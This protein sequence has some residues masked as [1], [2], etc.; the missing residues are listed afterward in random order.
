MLNEHIGVVFGVLFFD[1]L[2]SDMAPCVVV[3]GDGARNS[4][5]YI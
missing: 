5:V 3:L 1:V 4:N 2:D